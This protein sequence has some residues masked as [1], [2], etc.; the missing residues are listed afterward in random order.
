M[1]EVKIEMQVIGLCRMRHR[2]RELTV[3]A[4]RVRTE[5]NVKLIVPP[6]PLRNLGKWGKGS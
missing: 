2:G 5:G 1:N 3:L 4:A 6:H